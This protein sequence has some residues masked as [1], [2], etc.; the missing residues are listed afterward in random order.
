MGAFFVGF[1]MELDF[2][3]PDLEQLRV[4]LGSKLRAPTIVSNYLNNKYKYSILASAVNEQ[5]GETLNQKLY[6]IYTGINSA[7]SCVCGKKLTFNTFSQGYSKYCSSACSSVDPEVR[8]RTIKTRLEKYGTAILNKTNP[9]KR[10]QV[11]IERFGGKHQMSSVDVKNKRSQTYTQ[12]HGGIGFGSSSVNG[13]I[14]ATMI[15]RFGAPR[16]NQSE[17]LQSQYVK[18]KLKMEFNKRVEEHA[19]FIIKCTEDEYEGQAKVLNM[20]CKRCGTEIQRNFVHQ[21]RCPSCDVG[22]GRS[23]VEKDLGTIISEIVPNSSIIVGAKLFENPQKSVD[24]YIPELKVAFEFD[25]LYWHSDVFKSTSYH[26][27]KTMELQAQGIKLFH[28]FED[29]F[30]HRREIVVSMIRNQLGKTERTLYAR[31]CTVSQIPAKRARAFCDSNHLQGFVSGTYYVGLFHGLE[32]VSVMIVSKC[33]FSNKYNWELGRWVSLL[34][35]TVVGG[36]SKC[37]KYVKTLIDNEPILTYCDFSHSY[38]GTYEKFGKYLYTTAPNYWYFKGNE[39][40]RYSRMKF[41]KHKLK[42]FANYSPDKTEK[43]IMREAGW[44]IIYD[45][46]NLVYE[47]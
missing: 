23:M 11:M 26:Q 40:E 32:L 46:G 4:F 36:F 12:R 2:N 21:I 7:P 41:Q 16:N 10:E 24:F 14:E 17:Q 25:G 19:N 37:L 3:N 1:F 18:N 28:V 31:K 27:D 9:E 22:Y 47:L 45:C 39:C 5:F 35:T 29:D 6:S 15:Q 30:K 42:G 43:E 34:N 8:A 38:G 13:K 33:R 44:K 20:Q